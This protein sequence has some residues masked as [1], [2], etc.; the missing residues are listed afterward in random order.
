MVGYDHAGLWDQ[1]Y[2]SFVSL[3]WQHATYIV[4][5]HALSGVSEPIPTPILP[6]GDYYFHVATDLAF[7]ILGH[8]WQQILTV[9]GDQL[10]ETFEPPSF[11]KPISSNE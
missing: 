9:F 3:D 6:D 11:L 1:V 7:G 2:G 4:W 5:P 8:P 10:I